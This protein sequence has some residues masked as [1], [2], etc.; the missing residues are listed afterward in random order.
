MYE[1]KFKELLEEMRKYR[2]DDSNLKIQKWELI[3]VC[4]EIALVVAEMRNQENQN[5]RYEM[6]DEELEDVQWAYAYLR[7]RTNNKG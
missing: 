6:T 3:S 5:D 2:A 4:N 1:K 7:T